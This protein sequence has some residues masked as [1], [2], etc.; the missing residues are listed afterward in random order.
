ME[1]WCL[2][3]LDEEC[4]GLY[5]FSYGHTIKGHGVAHDMQLGGSLS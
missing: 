1:V 2:E 3:A 4:I 5:L